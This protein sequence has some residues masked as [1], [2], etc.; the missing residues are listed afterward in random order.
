[1]CAAA[2]QQNSNAGEANIAD[3]TGTLFTV[4]YRYAACTQRS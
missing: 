4:Q 1:M 3:A 2:K